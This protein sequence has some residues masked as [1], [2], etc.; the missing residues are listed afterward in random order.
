MRILAPLTA[1][2][3]EVFLNFLVRVVEANRALAR[4]GAGRR[5]PGRRKQDSK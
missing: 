2:E 4:P 3:Q 5:K 1:K